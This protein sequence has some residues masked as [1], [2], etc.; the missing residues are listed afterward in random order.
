MADRRRG[1]GGDPGRRRRGCWFRPARAAARSPP[2]RPHR[3][4]RPIDEPKPICADSYRVAMPPTPAICSPRLERALAKASCGANTDPGGPPVGDLHD[5]GG[6]HRAGRG[7]QRRRGGDLHRHLPREHPMRDAAVDATPQ[8][9][10]GV[11]FCGLQ[12]DGPGGGM[13]QLRG[14]TDRRRRSPARRGLGRSSSSTSGVPTPDRR[15]RV[16]PRAAS[17]HRHGVGVGITA[18][19]PCGT[20]AWSPCAP[21]WKRSARAG[22]GQRSSR[23]G[24]R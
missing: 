23:A 21:G 1:S 19:G 11:L 17:G 22:R 20:G 14:I 24:G 3:R 6:R 10:S 15:S 12:A 16:P 18:P 4:A 8:K 2:R 7:V 9:V 13:D 5:H